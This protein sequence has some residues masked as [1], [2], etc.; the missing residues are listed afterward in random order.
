MSL[1]FYPT[2][3]SVFAEER[4]VSLDAHIGVDCAEVLQKGKPP[5]PTATVRVELLDPGGGRQ[6]HSDSSARR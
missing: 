2:P 3:E 1:L 5:L 6:T 4:Q